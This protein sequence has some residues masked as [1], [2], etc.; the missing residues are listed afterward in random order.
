M[1]HEVDIS[2]K[3]CF[4]LYFDDLGNIVYTRH[5]NDKLHT[6]K[7]N[8]ALKNGIIETL[9]TLSSMNDETF[10]LLCSL[11]DGLEGDDLS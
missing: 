1:A 5:I 10:E 2:R 3:N 8:D 7:C 6:Y 4:N 11:R 9:S